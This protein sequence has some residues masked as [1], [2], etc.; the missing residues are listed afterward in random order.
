[1]RGTLGAK[2]EDAGKRQ[3]GVLVRRMEVLDHR[4]WETEVRQGADQRGR[5]PTCQENLGQLGPQQTLM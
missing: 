1:M 4:V 2:G 3:E 5:V